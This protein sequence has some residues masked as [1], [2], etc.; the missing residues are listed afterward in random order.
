[1]S[2]AEALAKEAVDLIADLRPPRAFYVRLL[3]TDHPEFPD[4]ERFFRDVVD[5]VVVERGFTPYEMGRGRP[6]AAFM[7]VEIFEAL[8]RIGLV[9]VDLTSV[10][11]NCMMELGYALARRRRVIISAKKGTP[12]PFDEDKL[13]TFM[14]ERIDSPDERIKAYRDWLDRNMELPPLVE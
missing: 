1:M 8:H 11:P 3:A 5:V 10:R 12:L 6:E 14:W 2:H 4:V 13:P 9:V 7:N